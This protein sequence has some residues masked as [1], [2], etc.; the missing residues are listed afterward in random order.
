MNGNKNEGL[1]GN[2]AV[3][4]VQY[5]RLRRRGGKYIFSLI[6]GRL[7]KFWAG[8]SREKTCVANRNVSL[9]ECISFI[10]TPLRI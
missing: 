7:G 9:A 2:G 3:T 1:E 4:P 8:V 5:C 10:V 6:R